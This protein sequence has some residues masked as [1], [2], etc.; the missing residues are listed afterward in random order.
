MAGLG[1]WPFL[2]SL[3]FHMLNGASGSRIYDKHG[4]QQGDSL[5]PMLFILVMDAPNL[6]FNRTTKDGMLSKLV[7]H[8]LKHR[9]SIYADVVVTFVRPSLL[10]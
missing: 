8:G 7:D 6:L 3:N 1:L 4:F 9:T 5:F 10:E 2:H